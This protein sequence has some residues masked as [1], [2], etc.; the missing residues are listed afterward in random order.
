MI[1]ENNATYELVS[2]FSGLS[3]LNSIF[4]ESPNEDDFLDNAL[5]C[6]R[7]IGNTYSV[8]TVHEGKTDEEGKLC[9]P[10]N[11][12][13]IESV[14]NG[15]RD[16]TSDSY[17]NTLSNLYITGPFL[18]YEYYYNNPIG[19]K[20]RYLIL[21]D[22]PE[23]DVTVLYKTYYHDE[24]FLPLVTKEEAEACAY[25]FIYIQTLRNTFK[26]NPQA[27]QLLQLA[28]KNKNNKINQARTVVNLS[29][30]FMNQEGHI[31]H[32]FDRKWYNRT[33]KPIKIT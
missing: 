18:K 25:Y 23:W 15:W 21:R 24:N 12:Y 6:L 32:S 1:Q 22:Y 19:T 29:Q 27:A 7:L 5:N 14:T 11:A 26:G 9:L 16:W 10:T 33:N 8:L 20:S 2:I 4:Q 3:Q 28:E 31:L 30:N 13:Q 17:R